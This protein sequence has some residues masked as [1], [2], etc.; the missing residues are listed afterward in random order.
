[1][2]GKV[3]IVP[4]EPRHIK[5]LAELEQLCFEEPWSERAL[6]EELENPQAVFLIA[7]AGGKTMGYAGMHDILGEGYID[8]VAV[9]PHARSCGVGTSLMQ[10]LCSYGKEKGL[11]F[12]T[13]EVRPSNVPALALYRKFGFRQEGIR[14]GF[15]RHPTEDA[16]ILTKRF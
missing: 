4:M 11:S 12:I 1:M 13:L 2:E 8:N 16:L 7:E 3:K 15:Y 5:A 6:A 14:W 9:F 10:A